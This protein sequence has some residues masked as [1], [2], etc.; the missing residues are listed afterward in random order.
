MCAL[1]NSW[2]CLSLWFWRNLERL[3]K[4]N[5]F[6]EFR[7]L[8]WMHSV[9]LCLVLWQ[10]WNLATI[11]VFRD[12]LIFYTLKEPSINAASYSPS[13][14]HLPCLH[15]PRGSQ[16]ITRGGMGDVTFSVQP[17]SVPPPLRYAR[18]DVSGEAHEVINTL[19][20]K[21]MGNGRREWVRERTRHLHAPEMTRGTLTKFSY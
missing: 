14:T 13:S 19:G 16:F 2:Q 18:L 6:S 17:R 8:Q 3:H 1:S 10:P 11:S 21:T 12:H 20:G 15:L 4:K 5:C 9:T 7:G